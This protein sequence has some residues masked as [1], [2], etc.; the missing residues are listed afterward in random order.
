[1]NVLDDLI[2]NIKSAPIR[3]ICIGVFTTAVVSRQCGLSSSL[4]LECHSRPGSIEDAGKLIGKDAAE[5]AKKIKSEYT[6][7]A[8]LGMACIN[9]A[10]NIEESLLSEV[11][12]EDIIKRKG[13]DKTVAVIGHF[14]FVHRL[15]ASVKKLFVFEK[16]LRPGDIPSSRIPELLE[17][18][19]VVAVTGTAL[20]NHSFAEIMRCVN[21]DAFVIMLGPSTP[22]TDIMFDYG[23]DALCGAVADDT[24]MLL[25]YIKQGVPFKQLKGKRLVTK[26][27]IPLP[28]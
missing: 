4:S 2:N 5:V 13:R 22:L 7:E 23:L 26:L 17:Q 14:P 25:Q 19:A 27:K 10:V 8:A 1:M 3:E 16:R 20:I 6:L 18:A 12:A 15:K 9:S 24:G 21:K 28:A 11:N